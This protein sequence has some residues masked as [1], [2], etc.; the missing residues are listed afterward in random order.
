MTMTFMGLTGPSG[1][2]PRHYTDMMMRQQREG[3]GAD[4]YALRDWLDLFNHRFI[5]LFFRA[6]PR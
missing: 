6:S 2:L 1:V 3:R 5:S 4:R